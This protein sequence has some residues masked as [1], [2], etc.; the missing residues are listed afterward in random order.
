MANGDWKSRRGSKLPP[1]EDSARS[2]YLTAQESRRSMSTPPIKVE[3]TSLPSLHRQTSQLAY[4]PIV[5]TFVRNGDRFFEGVKV[6]ITQRNMRSWENLLS[7]LSRR[8]ELP[9]GVRNI[10]TPEGG[11][12][13]KSLSQLE[14]KKTYVCGSTEPF[15]R[16]DY[17]NIKNPD[18]KVTKP[19]ISEN[20]VVSVF[21][22][23]PCDQSFS[24]TMSSYRNLDNSMSKWMESSNKS[25]RT[26]RRVSQNPKA[27][28][29][30]SVT[31]SY[32]ES[33][34]KSPEEHFNQSMR[35]LSGLNYS[36]P[37]SQHK[38]LM[39]YRNAPVHSRERVK[40]YLNRNM[41]KSWEDAVQI[42][43]E[44]LKTI[45]G[46]LRLY[47]LDGKEIES[48]SQLWSAGSNLIAVGKEKFSLSE[49]LRGVQGM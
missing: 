4:K 42:I 16:I 44:N 34:L 12:R 2:R 29:L 40:V 28:R 49:F 21:S 14:H 18:W 17:H 3:S 38:V 13:I 37:A 30:D 48:L 33:A 25:K 5:V 19:R 15:K 22:L 45:N 32:Q 36:T 47:N 20:E 27:L 39:I 35:S 8:I 10:Y 26:S 11:H 6:N 1:V 24:S 31:D 23:P 41:I 46:C 43:S 7:E 9:A